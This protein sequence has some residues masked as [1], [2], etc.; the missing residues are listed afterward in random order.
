MSAGEH[1]AVF[2]ER[3]LLFGYGGNEGGGGK[4]EGAHL[5]KRRS[6]AVMSRPQAATCKSSIMCMR[7]GEAAACLFDLSQEQFDN[8]LS[9][10][11]RSF[12]PGNLSQPA[13]KCNVTSDQLFFPLPSDVVVKR[14]ERPLSA[15]ADQI[16][17]ATRTKNPLL[18][19]QSFLLLMCIIVPGKRVFELDS[20]AL[21]SA[22]ADLLLHPALPLSLPVFPP[23]AARKA[24]CGGF[25]G[26]K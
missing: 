8:H 16:C 6:C 19:A 22:V 13:A 23:L 12:P 26:R 18:S 5:R 14:C 25:N 2:P 24:I 7:L 20:L 21:G 17:T 15:S 4:L 3:R 1:Q 9:V 10:S 11:Q